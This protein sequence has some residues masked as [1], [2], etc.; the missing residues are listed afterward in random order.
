MKVVQRL[1]FQGFRPALMLGFACSLMWAGVPILP[2]SAQSA[3][4]TTAPAA[5]QP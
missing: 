4:Q 5:N 3:P 2:A 1:G